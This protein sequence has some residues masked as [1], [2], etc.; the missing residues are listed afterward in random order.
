MT[1]QLSFTT[2][3]ALIGELRARR[4]RMGLSQLEVDQIAG[5][6]SGYVA[7]LEASLTNPGAKNARSLGRESLP[8]VLGALGLSLTVN[9]SGKEARKSDR[10]IRQL[11]SGALAKF[12]TERSRKGQEART[13]KLTPQRRRAIARKAAR[14]RWAKRKNA[15]N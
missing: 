6:A 7:K 12:L 10:E 5:L 11:Q 1:K 8:L 15:G 13:R 9:A 4:I 3:E 14:A 2:F